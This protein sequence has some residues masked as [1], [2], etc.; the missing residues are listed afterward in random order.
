MRRRD[1]SQS[2]PALDAINVTPLIDVMMCL[3]V[4]FLIVSKLAADRGAGIHLPGSAAGLQ[5]AQAPVAT[6]LVSPA[7]GGSAAVR[8]GGVPARVSLDGTAVPDERTLESLLRDRLGGAPA[9]PVQ[10]RAD[11]DTPW[12][13]MEPVLRACSRAGLSN[14]RLATERLR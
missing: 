10:V 9:Q 7:D 14:L 5:Q 13:A 2:A 1:V 6:I 12:D 3:I 8:W 4:F 11:R